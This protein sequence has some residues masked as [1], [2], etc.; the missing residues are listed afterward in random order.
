MQSLVLGVD[1]VI[2]R[3][4]LLL[5]HVRS[6]CIEY[7]RTKLPESKNAIESNKIFML[8][9]GNTARGLQQLGIDISDFNKK[10]YNRRLLDH[11]TEVI[12]GSDFQNEA[13][14]IHRWSQTNNVT[15]FTNSPIE[16]AAPIARAIGD[17]INISCSNSEYSVIKTDPEA[18]SQFAPDNTYVFVDDSLKNLGAVRKLPNW[19][20]VYFSDNPPDQ[21]QWCMQVRSIWELGFHLKL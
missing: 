2:I 8:A 17:N 19:R 16:W 1:G 20:P 21:H 7:V 11:L 14:D 18:Y 15:L 4:K 3:D 12:Y 5:N 10:V 9:H 13:N 6:N